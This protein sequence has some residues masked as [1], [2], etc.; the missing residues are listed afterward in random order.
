MN[1]TISDLYAE[2]AKQNITD[3][4]AR[5]DFLTEYFLG[6]PYL[7]HPQGEGADG[8]I[9]Q[10][11]FYRFDGFDC[12]TY[13]NNTLAL[14]LSE[15]L[16]SFQE[17]LLAIN[18]YDSKPLFE[19]RFHFM[20]VDWNIQNQNNHSVVDITEKIVDKHNTPICLFAEGDID[21]PSWFLKR[22]ENEMS[23]RANHLK[24]ISKKVKKEWARLPY[25]P[26]FTLFDD[27]KNPHDDLFNQIPHASIIE[28]VRPNWQLKEKIGT[29][30]HVSHVGFAVRNVSGALFF[31]HA[32][33]EQKC[34]VEILLS[35][36]LKNFL[37]S[38]TI[39][40]IHVQLI[41]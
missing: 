1:T 23:S 9:D 12:V 32:S 2:L 36:Y 24:E 39:K 11:P 13:V 40:G 29:N 28:I 27:N 10:A 15:D 37:E 25:L 5:I 8:E 21:R 19:N 35:D 14:A 34:V 26:L 4:P 30:L 3:T 7:T 33:S 16:Y 22:A 18:Y 31:R 6:K 17:K 20:S 41:L 38:P